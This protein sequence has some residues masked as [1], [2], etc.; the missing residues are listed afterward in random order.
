MHDSLM[1]KSGL[2][3]RKETQVAT[4]SFCLFAVRT[5][6]TMSILFVEESTGVRFPVELSIGLAAWVFPRSDWPL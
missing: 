6:F 1:G 5:C 2:A 3:R 4:I